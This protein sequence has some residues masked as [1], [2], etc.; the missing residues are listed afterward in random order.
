MT[1]L[2]RKRL[3]ELPNY[4]TEGQTT[5]A[6]D[7]DIAGAARCALL[8][9]VVPKSFPKTQKKAAPHGLTRLGTP[10]FA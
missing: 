6:I 7:I 5:I 8:R 2:S 3:D 10:I 4:H 9:R 1:P